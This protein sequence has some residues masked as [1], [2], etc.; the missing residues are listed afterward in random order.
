MYFEWPFIV[1]VCVVRMKRPITSRIIQCDEKYNSHWHID[2]EPNEYR[3]EEW[4][5]TSKRDKQQWIRLLVLRPLLMLPVLHRCFR[6]QR[7]IILNKMLFFFPSWISLESIFI[8]VAVIH[9]IALRCINEIE[10]P[11]EIQHSPS[12]SRNDLNYVGFFFPSIHE[13]NH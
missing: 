2:A 1:V 6:F 11:T 8:L 3:N 10:S 5:Q 9:S 7:K 13:R 4:I 12:L